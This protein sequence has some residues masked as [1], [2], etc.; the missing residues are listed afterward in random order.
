LELPT[1]ERFTFLLERLG[2]ARPELAQKLT[3]IHMDAIRSVVR[4]VPHHVDVLQRLRRRV[5]L[6]VCSNFSHAP[7]ARRILK[8]AQLLP[9]F[10]GVVI[11]EEVG[12]RKPRSEIFQAVLEKLG[13]SPEETAHV[14]D[15]LAADVD[16]AT[17]AGLTAVWLTRRV[18]DPDAE[19]ESHTGERPAHVIR[20]LAEVES[21]LDQ[22]T[23]G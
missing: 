9:L 6:G 17:R 3:T 20:D 23:P 1:V 5:P 19:L 12:V 7:T 2:I 22:T 16:G 11:S 8:E 15:A 13:G 4:T 14:G 18:K 21:V 10:D